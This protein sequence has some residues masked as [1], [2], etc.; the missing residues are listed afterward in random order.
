MNPL[1]FS[2]GALAGSQTFLR[3][4]VARQPFP[5]PHQFSKLLDHP[6]RL[7]YRNVS[8]TLGIFGF[9]AGMNVVD[10]GCGTGTFTEE[11]ARMVG[12]NGT[13]HAVDLQKPLLDSARQRIQQAGVSDRVRFHHT[14]ANTLPLADESVDLVVMIATMGEIEDKFG[15]LM[16]IRRILKPDARLAISEEMLDPAYLAAATVS[17]WLEEAGF[18]FVGKNGNP[19]CYNMIFAK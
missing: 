2:L 16:E 10:L 18:F 6:L 19:F 5:M 7:Q 15:A 11:M 12:G 4:A 13:V 17:R 1:F 8:E 14:G 3:A 9:Q